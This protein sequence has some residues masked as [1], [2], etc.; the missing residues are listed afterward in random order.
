MFL[1]H[2]SSAAW[3]GYTLWGKDFGLLHSS[4]GVYALT[5]G[6]GLF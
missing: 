2:F 4:Q 1:I 6:F 3:L 5:N